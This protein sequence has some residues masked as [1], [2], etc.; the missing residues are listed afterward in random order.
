MHTLPKK[1]ILTIAD[2]I[3]TGLLVLAKFNRR[4]K[5][6]LNTKFNLT[7]LMKYFLIPILIFATHIGYG[8]SNQT[9]KGNIET[10]ST[11]SRYH[12]DMGVEKLDSED[13]EGALGDFNDAISLRS[14][15]A[16]YYHN[17]AYVKDHLEDIM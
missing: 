9:L 2:L 13:Y 4:K 6:I 11:T 1:P 15:E 3:W 16:D 10:D 8:Q 14:V 12:Y 5:N 17:R 7:P